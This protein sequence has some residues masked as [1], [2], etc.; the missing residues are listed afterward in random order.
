[1]AQRIGKEPEKWQQEGVDD[2]S[3][4]NRPT[5]YRTEGPAFTEPQAI[6]LTS[7]RA[8]R[9]VRFRTTSSRKAAATTRLQLMPAL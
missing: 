2:E 1:M 3:S 9:G 4:I 5:L 6:S 8:Q 7:R